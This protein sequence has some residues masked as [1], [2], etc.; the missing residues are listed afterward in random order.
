MKK[1]LIKKHF[2]YDVYDDG[3]IISNTSILIPITSTGRKFS[4]KFKEIK[5]TKELSQRINNRGYKTVR[6][7]GKTKMVHRL[8][9]ESFVENVHNKKFVNHIDGNKLNNNYKNLEW[10]TA[11]E[12][13][14]HCFK[15]GLNNKKCYENLIDNSKLTKED[16]DFIRM[17][18]KPRDKYF[19]GSA[20][21]RKF[22]VSSTAINN[23][24]NNKTYI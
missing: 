5:K 17:N 4:G 9:A 21:A 19:G 10:V 11:Q 20:L 24:V 14:Q 16:V 18:Y 8:V 7:E 13:V 1:T 12:N 22:N 3:T 2:E 23:I 6:I 15:I